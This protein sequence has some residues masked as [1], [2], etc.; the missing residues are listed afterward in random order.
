ME[1]QVNP[2]KMTD[3]L[4]LF[5]N[6]FWRDVWDNKRDGRIVAWCS[7]AGPFELL[8]AMDIVVVWPE[9]YGGLCG[10]EG[11]GTEQCQRAENV[12][13]SPDLCSVIRSFIGVVDGIPPVDPATLPH[14]GLPKPDL[15][16]CKPF[17]PGIYRTWER[18]S[19]Q[20]NIPLLVMERPRWHDRLSKEEIAHFTREGIEE[21]KDMADV[22]GKFTGRSLNYDRL[23]EILALEREAAKLWWDIIG[24]CRNVPAPMSVFDA[25][26]HFFP[27]VYLRATQEAVTYYRELKAEVADRVAN[28][29]GA[30][31]GEEKYRLYWDNLPVYFKIKE[32]RQKFA[33]FGAIPVVG[34]CLYYI[35]FFP[36][37]DS[38]NP[39]ETMF[40]LLFY[41]PSNRGLKGRIDFIT[42]Q[43]EGYSLD[44]LVMQRTRTCLAVN[45]GQDDIAEALVGKTGLPA[46]VVEGD[47]CDER[48]YSSAEFNK[49]IDGFME[50]LGQEGQNRRSVSGKSMA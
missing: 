11:I 21:L 34:N 5:V 16:V 30:L 18:W 7:G 33:S 28:K 45:M 15:L 44:G 31:A 37:E 29:I 32:H 40:E 9:S 35:G 4:P 20:F 13:F 43:I 25:F 26:T 23:S 1:T 22:L 41:H 3:K 2:L 50:V 36:D 6:K 42:K 24:M 46:V 49:K 8:K 38:G 47:L 14:G 27:F 39:L 17:C 10:V 12:G 48:L 19:R